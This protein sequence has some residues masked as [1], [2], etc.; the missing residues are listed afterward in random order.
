MNPSPLEQIHTAQKLTRWG[1]LLLQWESSHSGHCRTHTNQGTITQ[2][3][4]KTSS[5][6]RNKPTADPRQI[7]TSL[8][9][10]LLP[11][12]ADKQVTRSFPFSMQITGS[13]SCPQQGQL[14]SCP[15]C[16]SAPSPCASCTPGHQSRYQRAQP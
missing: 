2:F 8:V 1:Y 3:Q 4:D 5:S 16:N 14:T 9:T 10:G 11:A 12:S 7:N 13:H 6:T 15:Q